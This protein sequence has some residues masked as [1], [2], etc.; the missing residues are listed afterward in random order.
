MKL[1]R[2]HL[3]KLNLLEIE[4]VRLISEQDNDEL[5]Q[6]FVKWQNQRLACNKYFNKKFNEILKS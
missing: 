6:A 5:K 3:E 2:Q 4:L 1:H